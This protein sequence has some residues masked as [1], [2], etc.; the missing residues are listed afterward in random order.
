MT[1]DKITV[2]AIPQKLDT[3]WALNI[4]EELCK[5][6][7]EEIQLEVDRSIVNEYLFADRMELGWFRVDFDMAFNRDIQTWAEQTLEGGY[8]FATDKAAF[9]YE[10][11][12]VLF[13]LKWV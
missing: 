12:A 13:R 8:L 3:S 1:I 4:E 9:E 10:K 5:V 7:S 6:L 11:D 2:T